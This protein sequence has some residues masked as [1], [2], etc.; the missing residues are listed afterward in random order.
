MMINPD[1]AIIFRTHY[2]NENTIHLAKRLYG[3]SAGYR[4]FVLCDE[5]RGEINVHPFDK[6]SHT[7]DFKSI[8]LQPNRGHTPNLWWDGDCVFYFIRK[9]LPDIKYF[10]VV[11]NDCYLN[12]DLDKIIKR[13]I[14]NNVDLVGYIY[15]FK[16]GDWPQ[17]TVEPYFDKV[18]QMFF[19][20]IGISAKL[21]DKSYVERKRILGLHEEDPD[22]YPWPFCEA[23]MSS[24]AVSNNMKFIDI[25]EF[26]NVD[27][28]KYR[29]HLYMNSGIV[30][31]PNS[32]CHPVSGYDFLEK[33]IE[34]IGVM[35]VFDDFSDLSLSV[36]T[37]DKSYFMPIIERAVLKL[38]DPEKLKT[39]WNVALARNWINKL[40]RLNLAFAMPC[41][42]SSISEWSIAGDMVSDAELANNEI[43]KEDNYNHTGVENDPWWQVFFEKTIRVRNVIIVPRP[44]LFERMNKFKVSV[45][46][47][48]ETWNDV[49]MKDDESP[50]LKVGMR[51]FPISFDD[52]IYA[53]YLRVTCLGHTAIHFIQVKVFS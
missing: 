53:K 4:F 47:D 11:E 18:K 46:Q 20:F 30:N 44:F 15:D 21:I 27:R 42:Q 31:I 22:K 16:D 3:Q 14:D 51:F 5:T 41:Q 32:I 17:K 38:R 34:N 45:S 26:L 28:F 33:R 40:P 6:I 13:M 52:E 2:W 35:E 29:P 9:A 48:G 39:F 12:A 1:V 23:M 10:F 19:P 50:I 7:D 49:Y 24:V 8:G 25:S 36:Q 43:Y 37:I